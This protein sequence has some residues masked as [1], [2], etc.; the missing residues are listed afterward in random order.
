MSI[1]DNDCL[2]S[3]SDCKVF[4]YVKQWFFILI[5]L[6]WSAIGLRGILEWRKMETDGVSYNQTIIF[7]VLL[8]F[9]L[10]Y[11]GIIWGSNMTMLFIIFWF[12]AL[13]NI[14]NCFILHTIVQQFHKRNSVTGKVARGIFLS[15]FFFLWWLLSFAVGIYKTD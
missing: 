8:K 4:D 10:I 2:F 9:F 6:V 12:Q 7:M 1:L 15:L 11:V 13:L 5:T 14:S 3:S